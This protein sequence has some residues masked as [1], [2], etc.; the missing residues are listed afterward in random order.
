M[1]L[2]K[3]VR[4]SLTKTFF[5]PNAKL[6]FNSFTTTTRSLQSKYSKY[7]QEW[8]PHTGP[9]KVKIVEVGPRDGLQN[10]KQIIPEDIKINF[11]NQLS[12]TGLKAIEATSFV[13][14]KW[15]PQMGDAYE[16]MTKIKRE[17]GVEYVALTPNLYGFK[18]AIAAGVNNIA[19][20]SA[21]SETFC[22]KNINCSIKESLESYNDVVN[23]ANAE[24]IVVRGY[25]SC[26]LGCPY[27]GEVLPLTVAKIAEKFY[28]MGCYE[29]SLA[30]TIGVGTPGSMLKLLESVK[31]HVP[32]GKI[33]VHCHD[34]YGQALANICCAIENGV[35]I[36]DSS[37]AGLGG[38]PFAKGATGNVATEDVV[39]ML[40][41]MGYI[42]GVDLNKLVDVGNYISEYLNRPNGSK[43]AVAITNKLKK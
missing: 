10:E 7:S 21:A 33:A 25:I 18:N 31:H 1:I 15:V 12:K 26:A 37:A 14:K 29:I 3:I 4:Q 23:Q 39:Y 6:K 19:I 27:E 36:I 34:T 43:A 17:P 5:L 24:G 40:G 16:I 2:N 13:S 30:D 9:D 20:F 11:I 35:R 38:C 8:G 32:I 22:K 41:G 28:K 42:T